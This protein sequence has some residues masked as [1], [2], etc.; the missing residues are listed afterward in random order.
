MPDEK[1]PSDPVD[2]GHDDRDPPPARPAPLQERER[3][4]MGC[5]IMIMAGFLG[6]F[7]V[8]AI[9]LLGGAPLIIPLLFMLLVALV[10]P[11]I[12]PADRMPTK[13]RWIG[14]ILTFVILTLLLVLAWYF[15]FL[16]QVPLLRE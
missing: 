9:A 3:A 12:N 11:F 5:I 6:I 7:F 8:P 13:A 2:A 15:V 10:T 1:E 4:D 16:R 14:R